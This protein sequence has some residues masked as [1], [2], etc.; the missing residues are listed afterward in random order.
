MTEALSASKPAA[1]GDGGAAD[2]AL[3]EDVGGE[4]VGAVDQEGE[5]AGRVAGGVD[6]LDLDP[7]RVELVAV[8]HDHRDLV[9]ELRRGRLVGD[10]RR[11]AEPLARLGDPGDVV[12]V[13][14]GDQ[15]SG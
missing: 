3:E 10:Q 4:D 7:V 1:P 14:V 13:R 11:A 15:V 9:V 8:A 6:R 5:V 2:R 12:D